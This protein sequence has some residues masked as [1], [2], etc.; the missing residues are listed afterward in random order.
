[1]RCFSLH[2]D[3]EVLVFHGLEYYGLTSVS[4]LSL[5]PHLLSSGVRQYL[6]GRRVAR[7]RSFIDSE[8][9]TRSAHVTHCGY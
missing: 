3:W 1:M 4:D 2:R 5:I 7:F 8:H 9:L 6:T